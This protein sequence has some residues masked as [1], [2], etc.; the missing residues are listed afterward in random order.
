MGDAPEYLKKYGPLLIENGYHIVPIVQG[1]KAPGLAYPAKKWSGVVADP[2][3][4]QKWID[5]GYAANG[6]GIITGPTP[7]VDVDCQDETVTAAMREFIVDRLGDTIERVGLAPKTLFLY[8]CDDL[9]PKVTSNDY[10]DSKGRKARLE[11][12]AGGQQFVALAI[13]PDTRKPYRWRDK[14]GPHNTAA[15]D[16]PLITVEDARAIRAEFERLARERGWQEKKTLKRLEQS[17]SSGGAIDYSNP[18]LQD[19][20]RVEDLNTEQL[21]AR[22]QMVPGAEDYETWLQIGFALWHQFE[23]S[24][25]GLI[26]WDEWSATAMNYDAD[27][28][29]AKWP[30]FEIEGKGRSPITARLIL[31]LAAAA[32]ET[33][34]TERLEESKAGI[35]TATSIRELIEVCKPIKQ[36][37]FDKPT[38]GLLAVMV[39]DQYKAITG[40]KMTISDARELVRYENPEN[41]NIP[42]WLDGFVYV[43]MDKKFYNM[44]TRQNLDTQAFD[45]SFGRYMLTKQDQLEGRS[46]PENPPSHVALHR[47]QIPIVWMQM[48]MPGEDIIFSINGKPYVNSYDESGIPETPETISMSGRIAIAVVKKHMEHLFASVRDRELLLDWFAWVVQTQQRISWCPLI[49]GA[50]GDGKSWFASLMMAILGME[51]VM[52]IP[53]DALKE[54]YTAWG[55]GHLIVFIEEVRLHGKDRYAAVNNLKPYI[56][57]PR[58]AIRRMQTDTYNVINRTSYIAL[59]NF[60]DGIPAGA[61]DT[62]Y[63]PMFS[64]WQNKEKLD[65]WKLDNPDYYINLFGAI[66]EAGALRKWFLERDISTSFSAAARAPASSH[67]REMVDLSRDDE[68]EALANALSDTKRLDF[69]NDLLDSALIADELVGRGLAAPLGKR[70]KMMLSE[71]GFTSLGPVKVKGE[72]RRYWTM[73]PEKFQR[74]EEGELVTDTEAVRVF[75]DNG[76][77]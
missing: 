71:Y 35:K 77:L 73:S 30:T 19:A 3:R 22:L 55:E 64:R 53:G 11:V 15:A 9:F 6:I 39:Q 17:K 1:S 13:H 62:R 59:T 37:S 29:K 20:H 5:Q 60:R 27:A 47:Y 41:R 66:E 46:T 36:L 14:R 40:A 74:E 52:M 65:A 58:V 8:R 4:L 16:L 21:R 44:K 32:E 2:A 54:K 26:L 28:I 67:R 24:D 10:L 61:G 45:Q 18:F 51:N 57:N 76:G 43:Q 68:T 33:L 38:R 31:K 72:A 48:Y 25:E 49:Q 75:L 63:F 50:E 70:L 42:F 7:G 12:L 56:A 23:G 69:C 34:I